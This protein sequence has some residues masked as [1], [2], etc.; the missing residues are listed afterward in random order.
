VIMDIVAPMLFAIMV[1]WLG[2]GV[3]LYLDGRPRRTY[4]RSMAIA[5][6]LACVAV[7]GITVV[8]EDRSVMGAYISFT[9]GLV[10]WAW[11]EMGFLMG[12]VTGTRHTPCTE[13]NHGWKRTKQAIET[14]IHYE[15][16]I[17]AA[18]LLIL[19]LS[20]GAANQTGFWTFF[21]LFAMR[22][23]AKLNVF[24]GVRN[25]S[26]EFLPDH[27]KYL[28]SYFTR[29]N[30]NLFFPV[31]MGASVVVLGFLIEGMMASGVHAYETT[32]H[33]FIATLI[34]LAI[35]EHVFMVMPLPLTPLWGW[36]LRGRDV[37]P[38]TVPGIKTV[39]QTTNR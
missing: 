2:T 21:V 26:E 12:F 18:G 10:I 16:A 9:C 24:L 17:I 25:L 22:L 29:R 37:T 7:I 27:L 36:S 14:I 28:T 33:A 13:P 19:V 39:E 35:L 23:S 31:S 3:I 1:W 38:A 8:A 6:A 32:A 5:T 4:R 30:M 20:W 15:L 34:G 11:L